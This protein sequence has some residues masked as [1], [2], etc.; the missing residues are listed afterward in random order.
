MSEE[1]HLA[2]VFGGKGAAAANDIAESLE[3]QGSITHL[4]ETGPDLASRLQALKPDSA[5]IAGLDPLSRDG[6]VAGICE[7]LRIPYTHSGIAATAL[8]NDRHLS[9]LVFKS[10]GIPVTDHVLADRAEAARTHLLPPPYIAKSR[11]AGRGGATIVVQHAEELPPA[12]L[13]SADWADSE[14]VMIERFLT[15]L[16]LH[17][18]VMGDVLIGIAATADATAKTANEILIPAPISPKI[19]EECTRVAL[20]AHGVLGCRGVTGLALRFN[21]RQAADPV[22]L[23]LDPQ[24]DLSR[25]APFSEIAARAGH[26]FDELLR[27]IIQ[28][29]S[30]ERMG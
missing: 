25:A 17:A 8:A 24:P 10:A 23:G 1:P 16:T 2:I 12:D 15:G 27:W 18:F 11:F 6:R 28:D 13:L 3:E 22:V 14:E 19:Y 9:K 26:S 20:R 7:A 21:E 29:A 4:L 5:L 30:C